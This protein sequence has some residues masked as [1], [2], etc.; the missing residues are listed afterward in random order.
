MKS[1]SHRLRM[2]TVLGL[3]RRRI[4]FL[5]AVLAVAV[6]VAGAVW[7]GHPRF[8]SLAALRWGIG[9]RA[10]SA[11]HAHD[12]DDDDHDDHD[13]GDDH[14]HD[15]DHGDDHDHDHDHAGHEGVGRGASA[16]SLEQHDHPHNDADAI[17]LSAQARANIGVQLTRVELQTFDRSIALPG[18][19]VERPGWSTVS[20]TAPMT[21]VVTRIHCIQ[22]EAV[23]PGQPLFELRLTHEDLLEVQTDFLRAVEELDV[24]GREIARLEQVTA[25]GVIA[26]KTLLERK[27]DQQRQEAVHRTLRESLLLHGLNEEQVATIERTRTLL[28]SLTVGAPRKGD[29][30]EGSD[31]AV[32]LQV[33]QLNVSQGKFVTAG[34]PLCTLADY[35]ELQVEGQ[36]FERDL[37]AVARAAREG[38]A[39]GVSFDGED[40]DHATLSGLRI[41]YMD[42]AVDA[43]SRT[44]HFYVTLP[45]ERLRVDKAA[46]GRR[47]VYWRFRP[48]QRGQISLPVERWENRIV[49]PIEAV[50]EDGVE[51]YVFEANGDHF[52]RR[53]VTVEYRDEKSA[54]IA[55]DGALRL[56]VEV[57]RSAA[58]QMQMA[59]KNKAGG[60]VDPHAGHNH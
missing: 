55:N 15:H 50:A 5:A 18:M 42:D 39:V 37:A 30:P 53:P 6:A 49:L 31:A 1:S 51:S 44:F 48:G 3:R 45:N 32:L 9:G 2:L 60:G 36:A 12:H 14:D 13:H 22:G 41:L 19:I 46:D 25:Q 59:L 4:V 43:Q 40:G 10:Q 38:V 27:Y 35:R 33:R 56:G 23:E 24:I 26:G 34:D 17:K 54:V 20:V 29:E 58:H 52:D 28:Q 21:G 47:F 16:G 7:L 8:S 57:A 11:D